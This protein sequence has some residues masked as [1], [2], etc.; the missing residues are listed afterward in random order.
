MT[1]GFLYLDKFCLGSHAGVIMMVLYT[2]C[3]CF[4]PW[5]YQ[6][7]D[8]CMFHKSAWCAVCSPLQGPLHQD[9]D[10]LAAGARADWLSGVTNLQ[11]F[12]LSE[13]KAG[14]PHGEVLLGTGLHPGSIGQM[15]VGVTSTPSI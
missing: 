8:I 11:G 3:N 4:I 2:F 1:S 6:I 13:R 15:V 10:T 14:R 9:A 7:N 5:T 12:L